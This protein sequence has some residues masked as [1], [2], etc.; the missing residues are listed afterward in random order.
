MI[1]SDYAMCTHATFSIV[2]VF[3]LIEGDDDIERR[4]G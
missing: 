2:W 1:D 4:E 3:Q